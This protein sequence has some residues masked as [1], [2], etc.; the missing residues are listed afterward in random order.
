MVNP[1]KIAICIL[2]V[3]VIVKS[4]SVNV[5]KADVTSNFVFGFN[6]FFKMKNSPK[7]IITAGFPRYSRIHS[8]IKLNLKQGKTNS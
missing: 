6:L 2:E 8:N 3:L 1:L 5:N 7:T 4:E